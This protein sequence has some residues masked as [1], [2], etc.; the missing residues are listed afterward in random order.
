MCLGFEADLELVIETRKLVLSMI[1][2]ECNLYTY[3]YDDNIGVWDIY[4]SILDIVFAKE[5]T[6]IYLE[7]DIV[8]SN[9]FFRF[10]DE[11]L[12]KYENDDSIAV[13][14]GRNALGEYPNRADYEYSYFFSDHAS[15]WGHALWK[16]TYNRFARNLD[17][18]KSDY[19]KRILE[20]KFKKNNE[21]KWFK[22][23][24]YNLAYPDNQ[25]DFGME[26]FI[27]GLNAYMLYN[28][29]SIIPKQNLIANIGDTVNSEHSD[30]PILL[31][32]SMRKKDV[33]F[34]MEFPLKHPLFKIE[35]NYYQYLS[36][37]QNLS[38]IARSVYKT[39]VKSERIIRILIFGGPK[40]FIKKVSKK[41]NNISTELG[42]NSLYRKY[43]KRK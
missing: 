14:G 13:V 5:E 21:I 15:A 18:L 3:F 40:Y 7:E 35:D 25:V 39:I 42:K 43:K 4:I 36:S 38:K 33:I 37:G 26:F 2:W 28:A 29:L 32:L 27:M 41:M 11:M 10:C 31:P 30:K 16:S 12:L 20:Y 23:T 6:L 24:L 8:A 22:R 9:S 1:D 19:Y 17:F 34:E